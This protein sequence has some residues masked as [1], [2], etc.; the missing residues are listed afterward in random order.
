MKDQ[1]QAHSPYRLIQPLIDTWEGGYVDHARDPGGPT[2]MGIT[3]A[4][5]SRWLGRQAT[6]ED[7]RSLS[8]SEAWAIMKTQYYD[9]IHGDELPPPVT[10][11]A[12]NAAVLS[13]PRRSVLFLQEALNRQAANV[14]VDGVLGESTLAAVAGTAPR[15]LAASYADVQEAYLRSLHH[16]PTFG[17]GWLARLAA[18]RHLAATIPLAPSVPGA[19]D[20]ATRGHAAPEIPP[21]SRGPAT[22]GPVNNALGATIGR[23]L[24]GRKTALGTAGALVTSLV[25]PTM[26]ASVDG[27]VQ[28]VQSAFV[29]AIPLLENVAALSPQLQPAFLA[30]AA[31]GVLGKLEKWAGAQLPVQ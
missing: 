7:V 31:W 1:N 4:T 6:R 23:L 24:D 12:Y 30:V 17:K 5:L 19:M 29:R 9:A 28:I 16:F 27:K 26:A 11:M 8:R 15:Q 18:F 21:A 2:N 13:G 22:P 14:A 25:E 20:D 3:I 10:A